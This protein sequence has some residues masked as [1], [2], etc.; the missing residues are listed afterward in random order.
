M[1]D[2]MIEAVRKAKSFDQL[3]ADA[4]RLL[5]EYERLQMENLHLR[6]ENRELRRRLR[7]GEMR[8]LRRAVADAMLIGALY[9]SKQ[10]ISRRACGLVGIGERRWV[11]AQALLRLARIHDGRRIRVETP[12]EFERA[13][14][15]AQT[16]V[17]HDGL[18]RLRE[19]MPLSRQR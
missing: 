12:G 2:W 7:D 15:V 6:K 19:R 4:L 14:T 16:R 9:F 10:T 18:E 1:I 3:Q 13:L 17:E 8:L 5:A 11:R